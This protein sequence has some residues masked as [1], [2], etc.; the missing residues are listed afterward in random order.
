MGDD[1]LGGENQAVAAIFLD[2]EGRGPQ[3]GDR[4]AGAD[5][6]NPGAAH[7]GVTGGRIAWKAVSRW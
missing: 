2:V 6:G 5:E 4:A 3:G 1:L 7:A